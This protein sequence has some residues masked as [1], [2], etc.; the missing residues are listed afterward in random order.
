M[1]AKKTV[2]FKT[3]FYDL[4]DPVNRWPYFPDTYFSRGI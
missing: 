3:K 1:T 4:V 2:I